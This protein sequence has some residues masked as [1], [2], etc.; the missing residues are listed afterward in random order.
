M[1]SDTIAP[2]AMTTPANDHIP[3]K[4]PLPT[5]KQNTGDHDG[6]NDY[7]HNDDDDDDFNHVAMGTGVGSGFILLVILVAVMVTTVACFIKLASQL[8]Y[9]H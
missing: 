9:S 6:N 4:T 2:I 5:A 8:L 3:V 1:A 7:D